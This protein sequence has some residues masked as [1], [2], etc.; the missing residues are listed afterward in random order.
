V[1]TCSVRRNFEC[2]LIVLIESSS[3]LVVFMIVVL[4]GVPDLL[5]GRVVGGFARA[6]S[7]VWENDVGSPLGAGGSGHPILV[8]DC[9]PRL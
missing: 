8:S 2:R 7:P 9:S 6:A 4:S 3:L 1:T 5:L